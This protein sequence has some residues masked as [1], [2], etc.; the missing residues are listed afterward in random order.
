ME[1]ARIGIGK[2][3]RKS[4]LLI[5]RLGLWWDVM[6][7]PEPPTSGE[8]VKFQLQSRTHRVEARN[9]GWLGTPWDALGPPGLGRDGL[10]RP[11]MRWGLLGWGGMAWDALHQRE[12]EKLNVATP[13][14][15]LNQAC[16]AESHG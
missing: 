6:K 1:V 8:I 9:L 2:W 11:G 7:R 5:Y 13:W 4:P 10:G 12:G 3:P 15:L 16:S 14:A